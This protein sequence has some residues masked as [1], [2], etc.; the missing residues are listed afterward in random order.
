MQSSR[1][2]F[3][4]FNQSLYDN[5]LGIK[6]VLF[7]WFDREKN[8]GIETRK[9]FSSEEKII[10]DFFLCGKNACKLK[11][12]LCLIFK[13]NE[14]KAVFKGKTA[15]KKYILN[16]I[17]LNICGSFYSYENKLNILYL[18]YYKIEAN[19][20]K[21]FKQLLYN[22]F[23]NEIYLAVLF[24]NYI[25]YGTLKYVIFYTSIFCCLKCLLYCFENAI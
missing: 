12:E 4:S 10:I 25:V 20:K 11:F 9:C 1:N 3:M 18:K 22:M 23:Q 15:I 17:Y 8:V 6:K 16:S 19:L 13:S 14:I 5:E 2:Y 24:C 7:C 21:V